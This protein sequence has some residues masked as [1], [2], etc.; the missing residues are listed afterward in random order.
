V[1]PTVVGP[2]Y[3]D[4]SA[5]DPD[6]TSHEWVANPFL[7]EGEEPAAG[8]E[9]NLALQAGMPI[10][11]MSCSSHQAPVEFTGE[12]SARLRISGH[13]AANRDV[14]V[15][16]QLAGQ[17][18]ASGLMLHEGE[19]ENF[20]LLN[21]QPPKRVLPE[22]IPPRDYVFVLDVSGSMGGFPLDMAK[23]LFNDLISSLRVEDSFNILLFAG[24]SES[25]S[26]SPLSATPENVRSGIAFLEERHGGGGT[27]LVP[28]LTRAIQLP[29]QEGRSRSFI[30]ITD[31]FVSMEADAFR[32]LRTHLGQA[33]LFALGIGSSV[34]RHLIE[35][36][37]TVG[38][39]E[40]F[41]VTRPAEA[42]VV[43]NRLRDCIS[44]PVLASIELR[45]DGLRIDTM[46]P[47]VPRDVFASRPLTIAGRYLGASKGTITVSGRTGG[48]EVFRQ[49]F[50]LAEA[51]AAGTDNPALRSLWARE[52][53]RTLADFAD[54]AEGDEVVREVT[55]LGMTYELL[56]PYTSFVA[57]DERIRKF[58]RPA[59]SVKQPLP[60][61]QGVS[62]SAVGGGPITKQLV[63]NGTLPEP[64]P[65][66]L[67]LATLAFLLGVRNRRLAR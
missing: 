16:Y 6:A 3:S 29:G 21:V 51:A 17:Q 26:R 49:E 4:R 23:S 40:P 61:P 56:T 8:F 27:E 2:R 52:R 50:S 44:S 36:L 42:G 24:S 14:I 1:Y 31:G 60:L 38:H 18:I 33:N 9:L 28:A 7:A 34:N 32:V 66:A 43:A 64:G 53:V 48:G 22:H 25:L 47:G 20:F 30:V 41:V 55:N 67:V 59:Q 45:V 35:G 19:N 46:E 58:D 57:I 62:S 65:V 37:A 54:L 12:T 10:Q 13:D 15:R 39:G 11:S 63:A 5:S